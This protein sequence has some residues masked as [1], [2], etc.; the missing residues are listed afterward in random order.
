M[1]AFPGSEAGPSDVQGVVQA[2]SIGAPLT[3]S[4]AEP[5]LYRLSGVVRLEAPL[6]EIGG[7]TNGQTIS[8]SGGD[9]SEAPLASFVTFE[10]LEHPN[11]LP[12]V[13]VLGGTLESLSAVPVY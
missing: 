6:V 12:Q 3:T 9:A 10:H 7:I 2:A 13:T 11:A 5:G 1:F 4:P 8:W